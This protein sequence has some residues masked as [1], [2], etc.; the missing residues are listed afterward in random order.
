MLAV[1][2]AFIRLVCMTK[3]ELT[4]LVIAL[5][6]G[7]SL[8]VLSRRK[9]RSFSS[10]FLRALLQNNARRLEVDPCNA[11]VARKT[12]NALKKARLILV[13]RNDAML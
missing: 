11:K 3:D 1:S 6:A 10:L 13:A 7:N 4:Y 2:S 12:L 9:E 5:K 8:F